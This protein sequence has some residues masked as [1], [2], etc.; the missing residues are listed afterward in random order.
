M[1]KISMLRKK[2]IMIA[3]LVIAVIIIVSMFPYKQVLAP[4]PAVTV[5]SASAILPVDGD[6]NFSTSCTILNSTTVSTIITEKGYGN[7]FLNFT[8][9]GFM[10]GYPLDGFLQI[11][12]NPIIYGHLAP[13]LDPEYLELSVNAVSPKGLA[14]LGFGSLRPAP[15]KNQCLYINTSRE[16]VE[17]YPYSRANCDDQFHNITIGLENKPVWSLFHGYPETFYNFALGNVYYISLVKY[18]GT[19]YFKF[20]LSLPGLRETPYANV[21]VETIY[22]GS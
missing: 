20:S 8:L 16:N 6:F 22:K 19:H 2:I 9:G 4:E 21:T 14:P 5:K 13:N 3:V 10:L 15:S 18:S 17:C 11:Q 12:L 7:S 1:K